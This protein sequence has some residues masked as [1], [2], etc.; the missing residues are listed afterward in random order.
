M[1]DELDKFLT[2]LNFDELGFEK[3]VVIANVGD[4]SIY[5]SKINKLCNYFRPGVI[6]VLYKEL[7]RHL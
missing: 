1:R 6:I 3:E 5:S 7:S 2:L 4:W